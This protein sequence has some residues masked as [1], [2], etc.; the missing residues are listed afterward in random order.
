MAIP[1]AKVVIS[2]DQDN[3]GDNPM[4]EKDAYR[5]KL[6]ARL[7]Q[8]RAEIDK[9]QAKA[10]EASA[11]ARLEYDKQLKELHRQQEKA[12]EKL[13]ELDEASGQAWKELRSGM[14]KAWD[15]LGA[16]VQKATERF[17]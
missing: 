6:Q 1:R 3:Y 7:G 15:E 16:A 5:Q 17:G 14:E 11:D 9:L 13:R 10:V 8:W 2:K 4:D 12:R